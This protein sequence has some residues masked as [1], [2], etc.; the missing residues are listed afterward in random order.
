MNIKYNDENIEVLLLKFK[1]IFLYFS[2][3]FYINGFTKED[4]FQEAQLAFLKAIKYYDP[5][6]N[7]NLNT[8]I[9]FCINRKLVVLITKHNNKTN[10]IN[11]NLKFSSDYIQNFRSK[12][13]TCEHQLI[14]KE[15]INNIM[16]YAS[17]NFTDLEFK[18]FQL[19]AKEFHYLEIAKMLKL[20]VKSID[21]A[22]QRIRKKL[23]KNFNYNNIF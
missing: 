18:V 16:L 10:F 4:I 19:M 7:I 8:F 14:I 11:S 6:R 17:L 20:E 23:N 15:F 5:T 13:L 21:N 9:F 2:K 1:P 22:I 3:K 12:N